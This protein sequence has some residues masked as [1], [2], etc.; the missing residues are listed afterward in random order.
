MVGGIIAIVLGFNSSPT[1]WILLIIGSII[2]LLVALWFKIATIKGQEDIHSAYQKYL[3][4][5]KSNADQVIVNLD[6]AIIQET[7]HYYTKTVVE[8]QAAALNIVAG[9]GHHNE[10]TIKSTSCD[11]K[12]KVKYHK[13]TLTLKTS[14]SKDETNVRMHFYLQKETTAYINPYDPKEYYIDLEFIEAQ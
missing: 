3:R 5:F 4:E 1:D 14:I 2:L 10:Q 8:G 13:R 7:N 9:Y 12:F 11:V 6:K